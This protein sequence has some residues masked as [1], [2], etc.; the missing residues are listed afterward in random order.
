M[1]TKNSQQEGY[2]NGTL[3]T[4][5]GFESGR[6]YPKVKLRNGKILMVEPVEWIV[7]E[8]GKIKG[9]IVQIPL[10]LAWA[11][12]VHKS[13]GMSM[14]EAIMD[15]S[16]VFEY[17]QGYV[18]LSR[19]R[20]LSG[21]YLLGWN[22]RAFQVHPDILAKDEEFRRGSEEAREVSLNPPMDLQKCTIIL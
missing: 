21:L 11:I 15:L 13:Q 1:F 7:E 5:V 3:G 17:G 14:D 9:K 10:R 16:R 18:A 12:T 8:N 6:R 4:V 20:R 22:E 2:V 19:V